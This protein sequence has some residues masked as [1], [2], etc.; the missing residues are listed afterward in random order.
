MLST[1]Q[2]HTILL[3][4]DEVINLK[5]LSSILRGRY[6]L[7][8]TQNGADALSAL[9]QLHSADQMDPLLV[10]LDV[11]MPEIDGFAVLTQIRQSYLH[12]PVLMCTAVNAYEDVMQAKTLGAVDYILKPFRIQTVRE[13]VAR[14]TVLNLGKPPR[15]GSI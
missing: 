4:D 8:M 12:V 9:A 5:L 15:Q 1:L 7:L 6:D 13:K 3:V 11:K 10:L 2:K 14:A